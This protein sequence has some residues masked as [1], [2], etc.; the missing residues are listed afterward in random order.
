[1]IHD[2]NPKR[3][4]TNACRVFRAVFW[5]PSTQWLMEAWPKNILIQL[6]KKIRI[7]VDS[8]HGEPS[9]LRNLV[10]NIAN[11][12]SSNREYSEALLHSKYIV[13][14]RVVTGHQLGRFSRE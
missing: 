2:R 3:I 10:E 4:G 5:I 12:I 11:F 8:P 14:L 6:E 7:Q 1:M 9:R 13:A